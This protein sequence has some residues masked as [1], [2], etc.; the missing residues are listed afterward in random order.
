MPGVLLID[1][2]EEILSVNKSYLNGQGFDVT[3]ADTGI[4]AL[5]L[6]KDNRYDCI[7]LDILLPDLDGFTICKAA[8]TITDTPILFLSCLEE[9]DDKVKGLMAGGDDYMT[10]PCSL[11]ELAARINVM[12]RRKGVREKSRGDV[13]ID[14][15]NRI[16]H[17]LGKNV[18]LSELEFNLF[19]LLYENRGSSFSKEELLGRIWY[20]NAEMSAVTSLI[21]RLRRKIEF[22]GDV[23]GQIVSEYGKG[24]YLTPPKPEKTT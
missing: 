4:N 21:L 18:L 7:V 2:N 8:R 9:A 6:L 23:T 5:A 22:A 20:G 11:K 14:R 12:L 1:D 3:C 13:N 10:K 16:I 15:G 19:M 24:Y 17:A